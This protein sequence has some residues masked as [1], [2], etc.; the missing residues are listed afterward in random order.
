MFVQ[1]SLLSVG[2]GW[3]GGGGQG[4]RSPWTHTQGGMDEEALFNF[5]PRDLRDMFLEEVEKAGC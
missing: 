5:H 4:V 3:C 1:V 2:I